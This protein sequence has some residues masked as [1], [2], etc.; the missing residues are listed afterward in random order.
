MLS[1]VE[2]VEA[3]RQQ[4]PARPRGRPVASRAIRRFM[5]GGV[6]ASARPVCENA[7]AKIRLRSGSVSCAIRSR[8]V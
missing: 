1:A 2:S 3:Q 7:K 8:S 5:T 6:S 4:L